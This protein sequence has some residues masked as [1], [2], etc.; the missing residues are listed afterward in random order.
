MD[1]ISWIIYASLVDD[2]FVLVSYIITILSSFIIMG[3]RL[4]YKKINRNNSISNNSISNN[5]ISKKMD[6]IKV[7]II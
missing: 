3:V 7:T 2:L 5:S 6:P 1:S 4:K